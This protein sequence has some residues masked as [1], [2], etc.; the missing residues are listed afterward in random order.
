MV[1]TDTAASLETLVRD[2]PSSNLPIQAATHKTVNFDWNAPNFAGRFAA[3]VSGM[4]TIG[5]S[6]KFEINPR[7]LGRLE[8]IGRAHV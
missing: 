7:N 2:V 6:K 4:T 8:E 1:G 5:D 3:E